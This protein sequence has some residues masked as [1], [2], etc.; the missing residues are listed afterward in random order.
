MVGKRLRKIF[1]AREMNIYL[2]CILKHNLNQ[3]RETILIMVLNG[4][5]WYHLAIRKLSALKREVTSK[6]GGNFH[7]FYCLH[8]FKTKKKL[9]FQKKVCRNNYFCGVVMPSRDIKILEYNEYWK[10]NKR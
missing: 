2:A 1:Y 8:S 7:Y 9:E 3:E 10:S 6:H 4:E 5:G